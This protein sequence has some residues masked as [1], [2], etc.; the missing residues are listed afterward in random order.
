MELFRGIMFEFEREKS[1]IDWKDGNKL[2]ILQRNKITNR[3]K[4][5]PVYG[6]IGTN[7]FIEC[8]DKTS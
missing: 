2:S 3:S 7:I 5:I 8:K 1:W 6:I 4:Q